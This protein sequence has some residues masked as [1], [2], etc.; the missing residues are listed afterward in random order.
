[1]QELRGLC[2]VLGS[3]LG[4][5]AGAEFQLPPWLI[6][7]FGPLENV[8][9]L[10]QDP[11]TPGATVAPHRPLPLKLS[12][13]LTAAPHSRPALPCSPQTKHQPRLLEGFAITPLFSESQ[14]QTRE[15]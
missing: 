6:V 4:A 15:L 12:G 9:G 11:A 13:I 8:G 3:F 1:M 7:S 2:S 14:K 5:G 10:S